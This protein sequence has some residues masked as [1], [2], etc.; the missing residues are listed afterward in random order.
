MVK[1]GRVLGGGWSYLVLI[2]RLLGN[3]DL[4]QLQV[5]P[6][7]AAPQTRGQSVQGQEGRRLEGRES[8]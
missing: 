3:E 5:Q 1:A 7:D 8:C 6:F 4:F 2:V